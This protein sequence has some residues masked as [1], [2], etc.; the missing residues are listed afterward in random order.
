MTKGKVCS[1]CH[2]GCIVQFTLEYFG[3]EVFCSE[4]C[5][6]RFIKLKQSEQICSWCGQRGYMRFASTDK[7]S[8]YFCNERCFNSWVRINTKPRWMEEQDDE[9]REM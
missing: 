5:M 3:D 7:P 6:E 8:R 4:N 1:I 9:Q 2:R